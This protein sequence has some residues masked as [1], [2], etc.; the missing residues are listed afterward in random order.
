[1]VK[2]SPLAMAAIVSLRISWIS[3]Q[4]A[5]RELSRILQAKEIPDGYRIAKD[6]VLERER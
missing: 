3:H 5:D 1:M 6:S 2:L 4:L